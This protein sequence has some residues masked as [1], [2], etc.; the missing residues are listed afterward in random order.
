[1]SS[2]SRETKEVLEWGAYHGKM[3]DFDALH[4]ID[5]NSDDPQTNEYLN[6]LA[7]ISAHYEASRKIPR[8]TRSTVTLDGLV[9]RQICGAA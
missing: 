9:Q 8:Q 6:I 5:Q 7:D 1:M 2:L 3:F 4:I